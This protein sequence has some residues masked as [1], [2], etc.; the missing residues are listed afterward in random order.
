MEKYISEDA[1]VMYRALMKIALN[2]NTVN[3]QTIAMDAILKV[4]DNNANRA[5]QLQGSRVSRVV[6]PLA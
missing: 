4:I 1:E 3:S 5:L 6:Q 2:E